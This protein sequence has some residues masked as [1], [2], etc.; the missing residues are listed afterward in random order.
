MNNRRI[1]SNIT[2][3]CAVLWFVFGWVSYSLARVTVVSVQHNIY[4]ASIKTEYTFDPNQGRCVDPISDTQE[5]YKEAKSLGTL[6]ATV[7]L[8]SINSSVTGTG[9][10]T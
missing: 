3:A 6:G 9:V 1:G 7:P 4:P 5:P 8:A 2:F 10:G